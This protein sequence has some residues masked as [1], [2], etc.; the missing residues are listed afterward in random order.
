MQCH[1]E[2]CSANLHVIHIFDLQRHNILLDE[3]GHCKFADY[4]LAE[5]DVYRGMQISNLCGTPS[6]CATEVIIE[7]YSQY[8]SFI[9][10]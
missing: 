3:D 5:L 10:C 4:G 8:D 2:N 1:V 7:F 6:Y 9:R